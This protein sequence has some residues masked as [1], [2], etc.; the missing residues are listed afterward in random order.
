MRLISLIC[1]AA[2]L[3]NVLSIVRRVEAAKFSSVIGVRSLIVIVLS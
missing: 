3:V 2:M 1:V